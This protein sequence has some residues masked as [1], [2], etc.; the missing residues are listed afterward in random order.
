MTDWRV[1]YD[2]RDWAEIENWWRDSDN[3]E[4]L[5][6]F[7]EQLRR[8]VPKVTR[9]NGMEKFTDFVRPSEAPEEWRDAAAILRLGEL[10][11]RIDGDP[12]TASEEWKRLRDAIAETLSDLIE[13]DEVTFGDAALSRATHARLSLDQL[14]QI[15]RQIVWMCGEIE[16]ENRDWLAEALFS[17]AV[18]AFSAGVQAQLAAGKGIELHATRG[19]KVLRGASDSGKQRR[20]KTKPKTQAVLEHMQTSVDRGHTASA[21]AKHAFTAGLG[22]SVGAN[23]KIWTRNRLK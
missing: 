5:K 3:L 9:E 12:P 7:R 4:E 11:A 16:A 17:A 14:V 13:A 18:S 2:Q 15:D 6:A 8:D 21:A 20:A 23:R 1:L 22:T 19:Q 10:D